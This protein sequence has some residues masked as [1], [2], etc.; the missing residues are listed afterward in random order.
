MLGS[1][2][3]V[4]AK[5]PKRASCVELRDGIVSIRADSPWSKFCDLF[6]SFCK[7]LFGKREFHFLSS[8]KNRF[9]IEPKLQIAL[10]LDPP[11]V[12]KEQENEE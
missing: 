4:V 3:P 12:H 1:L 5:W 10:H 6:Y 8:E 7:I 11:L 9:I 2:S